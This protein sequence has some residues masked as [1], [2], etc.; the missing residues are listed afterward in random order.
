MVK[1]KQ[2]GRAL[3]RAVVA[4]AAAMFLA[5]PAVTAYAQVHKPPKPHKPHPQLNPGPSKPA[6]PH[7]PHK[8]HPQLNPGPSKPPKPHK[9]AKPDK[10]HKPHKPH[11]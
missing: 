11:K 3:G 6:K 4:M 7:K 9:P 5:Q 8:P 1:P 2:W 10:P